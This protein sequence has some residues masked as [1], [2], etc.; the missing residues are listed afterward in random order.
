MCGYRLSALMNRWEKGE[1][2]DDKGLKE[3]I[4]GVWVVANFFLGTHQNPLFCYY[5]GQL[6]SME[7]AMDNRKSAR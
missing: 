3:L 5:I 4:S 7:M 2:L 6:H 1:T